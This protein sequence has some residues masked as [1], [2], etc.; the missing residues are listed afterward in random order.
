VIKQLRCL[1]GCLLELAAAGLLSPA[2][3]PS[4]QL[5]SGTADANGAAGVSSSSTGAG[6]DSGDSLISS[7][8]TGGG[9]YDV[10]GPSPRAGV[11]AA[12]GFLETVLG[13]LPALARI[14]TQTVQEEAA[15]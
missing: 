1:R 2:A 9:T 5:S 7:L 11:A 3:D 8:L 10:N 12:S 14:K 6:A 4:D 13:L 15:R